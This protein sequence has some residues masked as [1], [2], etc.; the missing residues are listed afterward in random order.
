MRFLLLV[1]LLVALRPVPAAAALITVDTLSDAKLSSNGD[2]TLRE[3][4]QA[5][6]DDVAVDACTAGDGADTILIELTGTIVITSTLRLTSAIEII[7]PGALLLA[8]DADANGRVFTVIPEDNDI[9]IRGLTIT[10]GFEINGGG[11]FVSTTGEGQVTITDTR[12]VSNSVTGRGGGVYVAGGVL[13][14]PPPVVFERVFIQGNVANGF[15]AA[16]GGMAFLA[17]SGVL[18]SSTVS[19]NLAFV[20]GGGIDFAGE[21]L[22]IDRSTISGNTATTGEGGG[23]QVIDGTVD[24]RHTTVTGNIADSSPGI[25]VGN[26]DLQIFNTVTAG[27]TTTSGT[28]DHTDFAKTGSIGALTTLGHN[29]V[30]VQDPD[31]LFSAITAFGAGT[32][33]AEGDYVGTDA[34]PLDPALGSLVNNGGPTLTHL[35]NPSAPFPLVEIGSCPGVLYDQRGLAGSFAGR[36]V[37]G[38][39]ANADDGCDIGAVEFNADFEQPVEPDV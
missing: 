4:I 33:N 8:V 29:Y 10:G 34:A 11:V 17:S 19:G 18:R 23:L 32:P 9:T 25:D 30:G 39:P 12:I 35:P 20:D 31:A 2:C 3:A 14:A 15:G 7:G 27:N 13:A 24:L 6:N 37:D 16:G 28:A 22:L 26:G 5:A 38:P 21:S 1:L 36:V